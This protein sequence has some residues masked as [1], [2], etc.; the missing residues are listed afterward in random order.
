MFRD[1]LTGV[2][3]GILSLNWG[4]VDVRDVALAHVLAMEKP[5]ASGRYICAGQSMTMGEVVQVLKDGG[6]GGKTLPSRDLTGGVATG[7]VKLFSWTQASGAGSYLRT[8]V[9]RTMRYD[10]SRIQ[11]EL[12][13]SFTSPTESI[14]MAIDDLKR[15]GHLQA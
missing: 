2:F 8:H 5:K 9:G 11:D 6:Y 15:W 13:L 10:N 4:L 14:P 7:L 1:I 3:P 12:G